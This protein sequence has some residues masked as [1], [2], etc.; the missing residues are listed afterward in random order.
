MGQNKFVMFVSNDPNWTVEH[1]FL[2]WNYNHL[3]QKLRIYFD[4][5][6]LNQSEAVC[7]INKYDIGHPKNKR[8][9]RSY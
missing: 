8:T 2:L 3:R 1:C 6:I 7:P 5:C 9:A 4:P